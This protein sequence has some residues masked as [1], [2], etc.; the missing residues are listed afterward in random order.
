MRKVQARSGCCH[1]RWA[2]WPVL[3][4][5]RGQWNHML[6]LQAGK[7]MQVATIT[8]QRY[9]RQL[10]CHSWCTLT[11]GILSATLAW[12]HSR[13]LVPRVS[14]GLPLQ[15]HTSRAA[16]RVSS[17][18]R[19]TIAWGGA[20]WKVADSAGCPPAR[21]E[22]GWA[23]T[24]AGGLPATNRTSKSR[25]VRG[26]R[27]GLGRA[28]TLSQIANQL[29]SVGIRSGLPRLRSLLLLPHNAPVRDA[30]LERQPQVIP[31]PE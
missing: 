24:D 3:G 27:Q 23:S 25:W 28:V 26:P 31:D 7:A 18:A 6:A 1:G 2:R 14:L 16:S 12:P 17:R 29:V 30:E 19:G 4:G 15:A 13:D 10:S 21:G 8:R 20:R 11:P 22:R 9:M 5:Q